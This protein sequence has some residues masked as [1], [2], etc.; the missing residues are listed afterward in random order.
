MAALVK[1]VPLPEPQP[2]PTLTQARQALP[3]EKI[4]QAL[5]VVTTALNKEH[6]AS[7]ALQALRVLAPLTEALLNL[8]LRLAPAKNLKFEK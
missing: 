7:K 3:M 8:G 2:P 1:V 5:P 4:K 6:P